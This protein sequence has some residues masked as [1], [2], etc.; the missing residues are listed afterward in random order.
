MT[1]LTEL[2]GRMERNSP[3][4]KR[5]QADTEAEYARFCVA[6]DLEYNARRRLETAIR[7]FHAA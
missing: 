4:W 5:M 6:R 1:T 2:Y 3:E 7:R